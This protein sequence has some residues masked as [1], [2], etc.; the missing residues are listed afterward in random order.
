[1]LT[2]QFPFVIAL[3]ALWEASQV[4]HQQPT[5]FG[6][7]VGERFIIGGKITFRIAA[8]A[9][10]DPFLLTYPLHQLAATFRTFHPRLELI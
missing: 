1:M 9:I 4:L 7:G 2:F 8:A 10:K 5:A 6:A 3:G